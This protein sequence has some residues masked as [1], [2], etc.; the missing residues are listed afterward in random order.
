MK[1]FI[2]NKYTIWYYRLCSRGQTRITDEYTESHHIIPESF[3]KNRTRPG[4]AGW[5]DGDPDDSENLSR[6]TDREHE[7]AH[8]LL[9]KMCGH[10]KPAYFKVLKGYEMRS[11]VNPNQKDRR[12]FSSRRLAGIRAERARIQSEMMSGENNPNWGKY[13]TEEQKQ[14]QGNK[15]RGDKNGMKSEEARQAMSKLK[16]GSKRGPF[17]QEWLDNM[18][19][20]KMGEKNNMYGKS[21]REESKTL[22]SKKASMMMWVNDGTTSKRIYK[23]DSHQYLIS[24]WTQGRHYVKRGPRGPYKKK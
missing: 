3:Y 6:L 18:S 17:T 14:S 21:H 4:P 15:V 2:Y 7:L 20:S 5:L 24:G 16:T 9:T 8:Y 13:W 19:A 1:H 12:H 11:L 22:Q 23:S 10:Y